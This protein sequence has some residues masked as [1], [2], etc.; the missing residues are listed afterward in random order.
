[1]G[2]Y[3]GVSIDPSLDMTSLQNPFDQPK[4]RLDL[5][6]PAPQAQESPQVNPSAMAS[7]DSAAPAAGGAPAARLP[8]QY[9]D[10]Q[11]DDL[12]SEIHGQRGKVSEAIDK[13]Q[14]VQPPVM[15]HHG[16]AANIGIGLVRMAAPAVAQQIWDQPYVRAL[17]AYENQRKQAQ[18]G[19][20][21][22]ESELGNTEREFGLRQN[23]QFR[24]AQFGQR[25]SQF[26]AKEQATLAKNGL[27][28]DPETNQVVADPNSPLEHLRQSTIQLKDA[29]TD[30]AKTQKLVD[31]GKLDPNSPIY[32]LQ[33]ARVKT[34][35][36]NAQTNAGKLG[37][38]QDVYSAE[39]F[40]TNKKG[41]AL[42]G[43]AT[44][45]TGT[46]IGTKVLNS[47]TP[48]ADRL[49]RADLARNTQENTQAIREIIDQEPEMFGKVAGR[50][51]TV[52]ELL[53]SDDPLLHSIGLRVHNVA[54]AS[55]GAHGVRSQGA[56]EETENEI[57]KHFKDG[58]E[59]VKAG[60]DA[61][62]DSVGT[63]IQ[64]AKFGKRPN[65]NRGGTNA[66]PRTPN[67]PTASA[68]GATKTGLPPGWAP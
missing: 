41:E 9:D 58:P 65:P 2:G 8:Y 66:G 47:N 17:G 45:E 27:M 64:D 52:R 28:R 50:I 37:L 39:Y 68:P 33:L 56:V 3:S 29:H 40:G 57:L 59:A 24:Q 46:P 48:T 43:V 25:A 62:D 53:G 11:N 60:L 21:L 7:L 38:A 23:E 6:S 36:A 4:R 49:K 5:L 13:M 35:Q 1:M 14:A 15:P 10:H 22:T 18:E 55:N 51:T 67:V 32:K 54:L 12:L 31:A 61:L 16:T 26:T 42:P 19:A 34:A 63:F 20:Q 44:T 30:L